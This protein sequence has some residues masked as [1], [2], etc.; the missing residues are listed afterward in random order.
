[1]AA[2]MR[3]VARWYQGNVSHELMKYGAFSTFHSPR[4]PGGYVP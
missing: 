3:V 1:M 2:I 4:D